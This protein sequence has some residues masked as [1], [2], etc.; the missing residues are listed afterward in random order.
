MEVLAKYIQ[1]YV[2]MLIQSHGLVFMLHAKSTL[3]TFYWHFT[4]ETY[5]DYRKL[6]MHYQRRN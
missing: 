6:Q 4:N 3:F 5:H 2:F 1:C